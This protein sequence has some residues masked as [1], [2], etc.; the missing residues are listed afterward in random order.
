MT[1]VTNGNQAY[2]SIYIYVYIK[3]Y[4]SPLLR[5][6]VKL[7][8]VNDKLIG[9]VMKTVIHQAFSLNVLCYAR[10]CA[11]CG[12]YLGSITSYCRAV[13]MD[14]QLYLKLNSTLDLSLCI[15]RA[16][17]LV[18]SLILLYTF[19]LRRIRSLFAW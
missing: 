1:T 19:N 18:L 7:V 11:G 9:I 15:I 17:K 16:V 2:T 4:V 6:R 3:M 8:S 12:R 13:A 5:C 10:F 14:E